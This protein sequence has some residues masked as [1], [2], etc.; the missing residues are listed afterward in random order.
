VTQVL[1]NGVEQCLFSFERDRPGG[2]QKIEPGPADAALWPDSAS[3]VP[4]RRFRDQAGAVDPGNDRGAQLDRGLSRQLPELG[5]EVRLVVIAAIER[6]LG[7]GPTTFHH[8]AERTLEAQEPKG[9]LRGQTH[10]A[11]GAADEPATR[12]AQTAA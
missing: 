3:G 10:L 12:H 2:G 4:E 8:H 5:R 1:K 9:P 7:E 11:D 6:H